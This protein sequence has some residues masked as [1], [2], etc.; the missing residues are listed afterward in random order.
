MGRVRTRG[1]LSHCGADITHPSRH[2]RL[3]ELSPGIT[4]AG[5]VETEDMETG[6]RQ[7]DR[8]QPER[9]V[10]GHVLMPGRGTEDHPLTPVANHRRRVYPEQLTFRRL[11]EKWRRR[12]DVT[13]HG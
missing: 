3:R 5:E 8:K 12:A 11:E 1:Q 13:F 9:P 4:H 6:A 7:V 2:V 10:R